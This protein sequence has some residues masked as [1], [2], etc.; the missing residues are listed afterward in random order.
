MELLRRSLLIGCVLP[1]LWLVRLATLDPL[2]S[3]VPVGPALQQ[4]QGQPDNTSSVSGPEWELLSRDIDAIEQG[5]GNGNRWRLSPDAP[6]GG[7]TS[8]WV[9]YEPGDK[10]ISA[11]LGK[12]AM[13]GGTT[14]V[15]ISRRDGDFQYR[16]DRREWTRQEFRPGPGFIGKPAPP[17][18]LLYP[19]Q[20][21]A[22][23]CLFVGVA[24]FALIP[25]P[26]KARGG[27]SPGEFALLAIAIALFAA[28]LLATGGSVQALTRG[29]AVT[30]PC[31]LLAAIALLGQAWIER[32]PPALPARDGPARRGRRGDREPAHLPP[33]GARHARRGCRTARSPGRRVADLLEPL[34][35]HI[36]ISG[37]APSASVARRASHQRKTPSA[38][39][40]ASPIQF[41]AAPSLPKP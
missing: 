2:V 38:T 22:Y 17:Y 13:G 26:T 36:E 16:V 32:A 30:L 31:W 9:F 29:L 5:L 4:M 37:P 7:G 1:A 20:N 35:P 12:L 15:S 19:F 39:K 14:L 34:R 23:A 8:H 27:V 25:T 6:E 28:P 41:P 24:L 10:P 40:T 33:V 3:I 21:V 18:S 11:L